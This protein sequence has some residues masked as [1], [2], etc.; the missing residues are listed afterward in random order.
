[1]IEINEDNLKWAFKKLKTYAYYSNSSNYLY[2]KILEIEHEY[3]EDPNIFKEYSNA[4]IEIAKKEF[5]LLSEYK[6]EYKVYPKKNKIRIGESGDV[7]IDEVNIFVDMPMMFFL[8]DILFTLELFNISK[9]NSNTSNYF[10]NKFD[11]HLDSN[12]LINNKLLFENY[13]KQY[14]KWKDKIIDSVKDDCELKNMTLVK[15]DFKRCFYNVQFDINELIDKYGIDDSIPCVKI[16]KHLYRRLSKMYFDLIGKERN[17]NQVLLPVGLFSSNVLQNILFSDFDKKINDSNEV[18]AFSRYVDDMLILVKGKLLKEN[19][20]HKIPGMTVENE[21]YFMNV[22]NSLIKQ[23]LPLNMSKIEVNSANNAMSVRKNVRRITSPSFVD[24]EEY[25]EG[26]IFDDDHTSLK[27]IIKTVKEFVN[28]EANGNKEFL[29]YINKLRD[30]EIINAFSIWKLIIGKLNINERVNFIKR[31][32]NIISKLKISD[33][34]FRENLIQ[35]TQKT[36]ENEINIIKELLTNNK[37]MMLEISQMEIY[38]Y[39]NDIVYKKNHYEFFPINVSIEDVFFYVSIN[40]SN[41]E[42]YIQHV[43]DIYKDVNGFAFNDDLDLKNLKIEKQTV[44]TDSSLSSIYF[45]S[46]TEGELSTSAKILFNELSNIEKKYDIKSYVS[47][48]SIMMPEKE[49]KETDIQCIYPSTYDTNEIMK[50][51]VEAKRNNAKYII[52]PEFCIPYTKICKIV[53]FCKKNKISLISGLTHYIDNNKA[54]NFTA[55][56]D[57]HTGIFLLK[58]KNYYPYDELATLSF[59]GISPSIVQPYYIVVK[60]EHIKYSTMTCFEAT[61]IMDRALLKDKINLLFMPVYNKDTNYFSSII[62]STSRDLSA[63]IAQSNNSEYGDS[64]ITAP[65]DTIHKEIVQ[66]KGGINNYVVV[67]ELDFEGMFNKHKEMDEFL[68]EIKNFKH[69]EISYK[70]KN[71]ELKRNRFKPLSAGTDFSHRNKNGL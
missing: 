36:L 45:I 68:D 14:K 29:V 41:L 56:Y 58:R 57:H 17:K 35:S 40:Y 49:I 26:E 11:E 60:N 32:D 10:G 2:D 62:S 18:V 1:M 24:M 8:N 69:N 3:E 64:R 20:C 61:N 67:G 16:S 25:L 37:F 66:V 50:L 34:F 19:I 7:S 39:I 13:T 23:A 53:K 38:E 42:N 51:I 31:V 52:F 4:L 27:K 9:E 55:I 59:K 47:I 44:Y 48:S 21:H 12:N 65:C 54:I 28:K 5:N 70:N 22:H 15:L 30:Y 63:F 43:T 33:Q 46:K 6:L 71:E